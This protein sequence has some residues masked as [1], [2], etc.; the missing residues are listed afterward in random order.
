MIATPD[1]GGRQLQRIRSAKFMRAQQLLGAMS[2][3]FG[4]LDFVP[5]LSKMLVPV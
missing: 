1:Q 4:W 3:I 2:Q 5:P